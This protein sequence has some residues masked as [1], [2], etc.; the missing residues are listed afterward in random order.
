MIKIDPN[1][2]KIVKCD[3]NEL[4]NDALGKLPKK[5]SRSWDNVAPKFKKNKGKNDYSRRLLEKIKLEPEDTVLDIGCGSGNITIPLAREAKKVTGV[6]IS[7]KMLHLLEKDA[8]EN[9][10]NN[11]TPLN[12]RLEDVL[13]N[14]DIEPHDV[15]VASRSLNGVYN[16][17][18][19]LEEINKIAKKYVYITLWGAN[20][21]KFQNE[22]SKIIGREFHQH[23]TYIYAYNMLYELGIY[24]NIEILKYDNSSYYSSVDEAIETFRWK[25]VN[26]NQTEENILREYLA[27]KMVKIHDSKFKFPHN[28]PDWALI[29]WKKE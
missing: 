29:W 25:M 24:A 11:I 14:K 2:E 19:I 6:D 12:R 23:P 17:K 8:F 20:N 16:I 5:N 21:V 3:W 27:E 4:W 7:K 10:L 22:I 1:N 15:V 13:L 9:G 26:L 18:Q 28:K